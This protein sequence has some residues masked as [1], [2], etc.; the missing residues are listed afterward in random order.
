M[1]FALPHPPEQVIPET[2]MIRHRPSAE[3]PN[4]QGGM[5]KLAP[6][7]SASSTN[8]KS[9]LSL[10]EVHEKNMEL[11]CREMCTE[12]FLEQQISNDR[13]AELILSRETNIGQSLA[14]YH[15]DYHLDFHATLHNFLNTFCNSVCVRALEM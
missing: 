11:R 7:T 4:Q 1:A 10:T 2:G 9:A 6:T 12:D 3:E 14:H 5:A 8:D 13:M 15:E